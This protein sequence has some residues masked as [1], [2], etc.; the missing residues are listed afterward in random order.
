M[1]AALL[2]AV[3]LISAIQVFRLWLQRQALLRSGVKEP[4]F[5]RTPELESAEEML[6]PVDE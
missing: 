1:A 6:R 2:F 3:A 5:G 4:D